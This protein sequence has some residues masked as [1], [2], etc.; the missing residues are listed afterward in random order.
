MTRCS[1]SGNGGNPGDCGGVTIGKSSD[2]VG[3]P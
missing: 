1:E 2:E 3:L